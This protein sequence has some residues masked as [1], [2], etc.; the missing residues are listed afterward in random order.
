[1]TRSLKLVHTVLLTLVLF[2]QCGIGQFQKSAGTSIQDAAKASAADR[3][4]S[5]EVL[6]DTSGFKILPY[7]NRVHQIAGEK[8]RHLITSSGKDF[9]HRN[10]TTVVEFTITRNGEIQD[11][12]I[13][14]SSG[15]D[16]LDELALQS[17]SRSSPL[18]V[19]PA[20]FAAKELKLKFHFAFRGR[21]APFWKKKR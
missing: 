9:T 2:P 8:W 14:E 3:P 16:D 19:L 20:G 6:S 11:L 13:S 15:Q 10:G 1:M 4:Q 12:H 5:T 21:K 18:P 7:V 17:V